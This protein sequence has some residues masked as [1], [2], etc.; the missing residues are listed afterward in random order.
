MYG[1]L[2]VSNNYSKCM[3]FLY[4]LQLY[5]LSACGMNSCYKPLQQ[6]RGHNRTR[7][8][9]RPRNE[10]EVT[11]DHQLKEN[12][13]FF[14]CDFHI[15]FTPIFELGKGKRNLMARPQKKNINLKGTLSNKYCFEL[16]KVCS[17]FTDL[18]VDALE[19]ILTCDRSDMCFLHL[20]SHQKM[21]E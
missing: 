20:D 17:Q 19:G 15:N 5:G 9:S 1:S 18:H 7:T 16:T 21:A 4:I 8:A 10:R 13:F 11:A 2:S 3:R 14:I 12:K 6:R